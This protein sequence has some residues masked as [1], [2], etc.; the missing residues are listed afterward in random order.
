MRRTGRAEAASVPSPSSSAGVLG[1]HTRYHDVYLPGAVTTSVAR[2]TERQHRLA[3]PLQLTTTL[4]EAAPSD[5]LV[6]DPFSGSGT[7]L[8]AAKQLGRRA[9]GIEIDEASCEVAARRLMPGEPVR[10]G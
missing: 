4:V 5:S 1:R 8:V 7:T 2:D 10:A 6:L 9:V 3:K